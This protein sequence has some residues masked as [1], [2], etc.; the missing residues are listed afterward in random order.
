MKA[1]A[2]KL[3]LDVDNGSLTPE[4]AQINLLNLLETDAKVDPQTFTEEDF[5]TVPFGL[6]EIFWSTGGSSLASIGGLRD[7]GRWIAPTNWTSKDSPTGRLDDKSGDI[8]KLVL[9][10]KK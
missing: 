4:E 2:Y 6:Y 3:F 1:E 7:G 5:P 10:Y 8:S 9:L